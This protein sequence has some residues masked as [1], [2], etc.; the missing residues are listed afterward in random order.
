MPA[1]FSADRRRRTAE[2]YAN[3]SEGYARGQPTRDLLTVAGGQRPG[4]P[5]SRCWW[6]ATT[7][8]HHVKDRARNPV[9]RP[10]DVTQRFS[11]LPPFPNRCLVADSHPRSSHALHDPSDHSSRCVDALNLPRR[12]LGS[13]AR[14][15]AGGSLSAAGRAP[16]ARRSSG[17]CVPRC[18]PRGRASPTRATPSRSD[19]DRGGAGMGRPGPPG[20]RGGAVGRFVT[21]QSRADRIWCSTVSV[22]T[23][24]SWWRARARP[25]TTNLGASDRSYGRCRRCGRTDRAHTRLGNHRTVSTSA[26]RTAR[27]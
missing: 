13:P 24:R 11:A 16:R 10:A 22:D 9:D 3:L 18:D 7:G 25:S 6:D 2:P 20:F 19:R 12:F 27:P 15:A 4:R 26:H 21:A 1:H 17:R 5:T 23:H 8:P 14:A